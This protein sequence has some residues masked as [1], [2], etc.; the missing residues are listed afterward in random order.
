MASPTV[1]RRETVHL[2]EHKLIRNHPISRL[3]SHDAERGK[4]RSAH[5]HVIY[6]VRLR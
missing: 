6:A 1:A 4:T 2:L 3:A 5:H